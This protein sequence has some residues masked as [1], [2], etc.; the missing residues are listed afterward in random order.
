MRFDAQKLGEYAR[1][2]CSLD[3]E[4]L[5]TGAKDSVT[6][7]IDARAGDFRS[8]ASIEQVASAHQCSRV[9]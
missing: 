2:S 8:V 9:P 1:S 7:P 6:R 4:L 3:A 5:D